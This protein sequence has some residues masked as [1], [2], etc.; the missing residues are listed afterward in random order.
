MTTK[1]DLPG[2]ALETATSEDRERTSRARSQDNMQVTWPNETD[3]RA[4][5]R[6]HSWPRPLFGF[7]EKFI[8]TMLA[9]DDNFALAVQESAVEIRIPAQQITIPDA[10]LRE[11]DALYDERGEN[12]RPTGWGPL[13]EGLREI[14][15]AVEAGVVVVIDG[16]TLTSWGSFYD[17]AHGRYHMLEDGYDS[18]IGDDNS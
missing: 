17:W 18:W 8:E 1:K 13:V 5:S 6:Q 9:S 14:R 7:K 10:E 11:F 15:R 2:W 3:L 4:W 16:R 12:G